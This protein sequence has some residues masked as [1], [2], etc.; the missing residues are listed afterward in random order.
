M[1]FAKNFDRYTITGTLFIALFACVATYIADIKFIAHLG[2]S[3]LVIAIILGI[4]YGN[5]IHSK[6][7]LQL[8]SGI[9]FSAKQ[10]LRLSIILYG[11]RVS[12]QQ[13]F[14]V[15]LEGLLIDMFVVTTG[16]VGGAYIGA[17]LFG[18]D[19]HL[20]ILISSGSAICGAAAVL[21]VEGVIKSESH[22]SSVAVGTVIIFG[23]LAMFIYP[24]LYHH[25]ILSFSSNQFG[26]FAGASIHEV[27]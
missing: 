27:A 12:F 22:K 24:I 14:A 7:S 10:L 9:Q 23:T 25:E 21:A 4:I 15:G 1:Y 16:L 5:S 20:A 2:M 26:I 6:F 18:L 11:F 19:R 8:T 3:P 17:R 13:I